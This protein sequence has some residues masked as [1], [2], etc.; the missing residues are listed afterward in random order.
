MQQPETP[1]RHGRLT[2]YVP[3]ILWIGLIFFFSTMQGSM[4]NTSGFIR[5]ILVFLFPGASEETL[6][7]YHVYIRKFAHFAEY[8]G[9]A[10]W[11]SRAFWPSSAEFLK[12]YWYFGAFLLVLLVASTDEFNQSFNSARTGSIYDVMLDA[13]GGL[14]MI[15]MLYGYK[16]L[17]EN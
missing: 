11:A 1:R 16:K 7:I 5:P 12:K 15:L 6:I 9:L 4:S 3:L 10:F 17:F 13:F 2:R 8:A 14:V